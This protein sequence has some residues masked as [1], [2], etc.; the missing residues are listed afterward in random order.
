MSLIDFLSLTFANIGNDT[1]SLNKKYSGTKRLHGFADRTSAIMSYDSATRSFSITQTGGVKYWFEGVEIIANET[2]T[3]QH[4]QF[5]N[6]Y[7]IYFQDDSGV[8][9]VTTTPWDLLVHVPVC[10]VYY[11]GTKGIAWE[12]RHGNDRDRN[13]HRYLHETHGTQYISGLNITDYTLESS[14]ANSTKFSIT[15][16]LIADEDIRFPTSGITTSQN[17]KVW[18]RTTINSWTWSDTTHPH[19][20]ISPGVSYD[21]AGIIT[22]APQ[23]SYVCYY[24]FATTT[25]TTPNVFLLMG[26]TYYTTYDGAV[27]E[28]L[29]N[30]SFTG[31]PIKECVPLYKLIYKSL[32]TSSSSG[33]V[34]MSVER[35]INTGAYTS[36]QS[37]QY[38]DFLSAK[39]PPTPLSGHLTMYANTFANKIVPQF[40]DS[41]G[42][43]NGIQTALY[44]QNVV[45]MA[46]GTGTTVATQGCGVR[47]IVSGTNAA[48]STPSVSN[49]NAIMAM[50]RIQLSTGTTATGLA[51]LTPSD[52]FLWRGNAS[53]LGGFYVVMRVAF[54]ATNNDLKVFLGL[55]NTDPTAGV[56][57]STL[58]N[59]IGIILDSTDT[60]W[61]ISSRNSTTTTKTPFPSGLTRTTVFSDSNSIWDVYFYAKPN[62]TTIY[63]MI[64]NPYTNQTV[65]E[66]QAI[67]SNIPLNNVFLSPMV[68]ISSTT[69]TVAKTIGINKIYMETDL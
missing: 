64:F 46:P 38:L 68:C 37:T 33:G 27:Y 3:I 36:K 25:L 66:T 59:H 29:A 52:R 8:L 12:E 53:K 56:E 31:F 28:S 18:Y 21:N 40:M 50:K 5:V 9:S 67:T 55:S 10:L 14:L 57:L 45:I 24:V 58:N 20:V 51:A 22:D 15:S 19:N 23:N 4:S 69:N 13:N 63:V 11:D 6:N 61:Q 42:L 49:T 48:L 32:S 54:T 41:N 7:F 44:G 35:L 17:Y 30:L 47:T 2:L 1:K 39:E 43:A 60:I 65:L 26:Q 62:D 16:G 34:L